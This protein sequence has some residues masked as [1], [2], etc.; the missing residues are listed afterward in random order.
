MKVFF[1]FEEA[2]RYVS[3]GPFFISYRNTLFPFWW[4]L[5]GSG[6][7]TVFTPGRFDRKKP[8][9]A[10]QRSS[11]ASD[12]ESN[13]VSVFDP[14]LMRSKDLALGW[15]MGVKNVDHGEMLASLV[16]NLAKEFSIDGSDLLVYASSGGG[17]P[18]LR[19]ASRFP[20]V[21]VYMTN[22]QTDPREYYPR[23]YNQMAKVSFKG[24]SSEEVNE[25]YGHRLSSYSWDGDFNLCYAQNLTDNFH[26]HNHFLPYVEAHR[27][28]EPA[29]RATFMT[30]EDELSGHG[31]LPRSTELAIIRGLHR[32]KSILPLLPGGKEI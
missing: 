21:T 16:L 9:P 8:I 28:A 7:W 11:Y 30:Y 4:N 19:I 26:Y 13:V 20:G 5:T 6:K 32:R 12:L 3:N 23:F 22:V 29:K 1:S 25:K 10:F 2:K 14:L 27:N 24:L 17:L 18:A 31:P 15:F